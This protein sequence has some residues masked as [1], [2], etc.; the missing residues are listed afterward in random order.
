MKE[1]VPKATYWPM[2]LCRPPDIGMKGRNRG[3]LLFEKTILEGVQ[4][5]Q[6]GQ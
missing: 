6:A 5:W 3:A 1:V 4:G 2:G